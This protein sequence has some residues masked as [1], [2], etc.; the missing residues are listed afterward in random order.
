MDFANSKWLRPTFVLLLLLSNPCLGAK[1]GAAPRLS[2]II[3][4]IGQDPAVG[5]R[6]VALPFPAAIAVLPFLPA[7]TEIARAAHENGKEVLLHQPMENLARTSLG[8]GGLTLAMERAEI[9]A[10]LGNAIDSVPHCVGVSNHTGSLLTQEPL[11]MGWVMSELDRRG[12]YFIDSR[13]THHT[14]ALT[15][16][17]LEAVP[18][19]RRDVF[20]D[21]QRTEQYL[22]SALERAVEHASRHGYAVIVAHPYD[23]TLTF[24]ESRIRELHDIEIV[25]PSKLLPNPGVRELVRR[26]ERERLLVEF[27]WG[28]AAPEGSEGEE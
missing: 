24:L 20:L 8:P 27:W 13:T 7:S 18:V 3:D 23:V 1:G 11:Q 10:A 19:L 14:V 26:G 15:A 22:T 25:P 6:A 9:I 28:H 21:N 16:A 12:L 4:D 2:I 17:E 5:R